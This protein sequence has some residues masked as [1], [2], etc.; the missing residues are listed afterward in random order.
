MGVFNNINIKS[1]S[2][3]KIEKEE[4]ENALNRNWSLNSKDI[5]VNVSNHK[6]TLMGTVDSWYQKEEAARIAWNAH[7]V[8][9]V[10]NELEI[11]YEYKLVD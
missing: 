7:G 5:E 8:W 1:E 4:I 9:A 2:N 6:V 10:N 11:E 3:N